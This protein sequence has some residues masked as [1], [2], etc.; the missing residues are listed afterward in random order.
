MDAVNAFNQEVRGAQGRS[1][2]GQ[3]GRFSRCPRAF[4]HRVRVGTLP[5]LGFRG[6]GPGA[7]ERS[8]P[9]P[10]ADPAPLPRQCPLRPLPACAGSGFSNMALEFPARLSA[11]RGRDPA[12]GCNGARAGRLR[13]GSS[14]GSWGR[15]SSCLSSPVAQ[16]AARR[17]L[18]SD[19]GRRRVG[20]G[21]CPP[22]SWIDTLTN[23]HREVAP[24]SFYLERTL[25]VHRDT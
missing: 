3:P 12:R 19:P 25:S 23:E 13:G 14:R 22:A 18:D 10:G 17:P 21:V 24:W 1:A 2:A 9:P 20:E 16:A 6:S 8:R 15:H 4:E 11:L 5:A 7:G